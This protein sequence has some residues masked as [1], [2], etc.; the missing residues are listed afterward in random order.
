[1]DTDLV[2]H[3]LLDSLQFLQTSTAGACGAI[4][5]TTLIHTPSLASHKRLPIPHFSGNFINFRFPFEKHSEF[6]RHF[7]ARYSVYNTLQKSLIIFF[8]YIYNLLLRAPLKIM[9]LYLPRHRR[10]CL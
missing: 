5:Q 7:A 10:A 9:Q 3:T 8:L 1:M 2:Q 6:A 4:F